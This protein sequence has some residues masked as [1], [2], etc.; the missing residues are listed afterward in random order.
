MLLGIS[1]ELIRN[2]NP[3]P[4]KINKKKWA[5]VS[6]WFPSIKKISR[7]LHAP[8]RPRKPHLHHPKPPNPKPQTP[9]PKPH[10]THT[11]T[12]THTH[13]QLKRQNISPQKPIVETQ[14]TKEKPPKPSKAKPPKQNATPRSPRLVLPSASPPA[15]RLR[16]RRGRR[17]PAPSAT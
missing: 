15:P 13:T 3:P 6:F 11:H 17:A 12:H 7:R 16:R 1:P 10:K 14:E 2:P 4:T 9:N 8:I 5:S